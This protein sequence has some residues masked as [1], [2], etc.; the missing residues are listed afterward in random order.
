MRS[1][2][3]ICAKGVENLR[4]RVKK[5]TRVFEKIYAWGKNFKWLLG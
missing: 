4:D 5:I 3:F 1:V 2:C